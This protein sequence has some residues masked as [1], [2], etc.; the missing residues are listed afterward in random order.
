MNWRCQ[1][2][3]LMPNGLNQIRIGITGKKLIEF[4]NNSKR[5]LTTKRRLFFLRP[6]NKHVLTNRLINKTEIG[7]F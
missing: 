1:I 2:A 7:H 4:V 3:E 6:S 5:L